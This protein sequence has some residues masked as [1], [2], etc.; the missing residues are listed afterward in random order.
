M[1]APPPPAA[2]LGSFFPV[3]GRVTSPL[4]ICFAEPVPP[5]RCPPSLKS[6]IYKSSKRTNESPSRS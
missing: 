6:D 5:P 1:I 3:A 4:P 2:A